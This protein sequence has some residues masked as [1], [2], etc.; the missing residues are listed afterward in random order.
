MIEELSRGRGPRADRDQPLRRAVGHP[1]RAAATCAS[2][3]AATSSRSSSIGGITRVPE[4]RHLPRVQVGARGLQP[5]AG[6]GGRRL[7]HQGDPHRAGRLLDRLGR[8]VGQARRA[9]RRLRRRCASAAAEAASQPRWHAAA[10]RCATRK[11]DPEDRRRR[12]AAAADLLRRRPAR[13]SPT[14]DYESRLATWREWEPVSI[15]AHGG[16]T[17]ARSRPRACCL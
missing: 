12:G 7:R 13:R 9:D 4:H 14:A 2:R 17:D 5:G 16:S 1:G 15:E 3:A 6:P 8:P 10:I 11:A